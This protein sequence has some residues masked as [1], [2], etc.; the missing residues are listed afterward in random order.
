MTLLFII[1]SLFFT[2]TAGAFFGVVYHANTWAEGPKRTLIS[3]LIA[4]LVGC[5]IG[6]MFT[7]QFKNEAEKWN[8]GTHLNC[9]GTWKIFDVEKSKHSSNEIYFYQCEKCG[10]VQRFAVYF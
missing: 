1:T 4:I 2:I 8:D 10:K 6:G 9:G 7:A 5:L 3:I